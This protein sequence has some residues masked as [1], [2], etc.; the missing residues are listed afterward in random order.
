MRIAMVRIRRSRRWRGRTETG[1]EGRE[2]G[3]S[4]PAARRIIINKQLS[5]N[6]EKLTEPIGPARLPSP[7]SQRSEH[8]NSLNTPFRGPQVE[9]IPSSL[10]EKL[11]LDQI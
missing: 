10:K 6:D 9:L 1:E 2:R 7:P 11:H 5:I 8:W 4:I 3:A